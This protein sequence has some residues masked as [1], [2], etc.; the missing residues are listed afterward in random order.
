MFGWLQKIF[1][2]ET[3]EPEELTEEKNARVTTADRLHFYLQARSLL[4]IQIT[5][6]MAVAAV[7]MVAVAEIEVFEISLCT[8]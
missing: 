1:G 8:V 5:Q 2:S 7:G 4:K 3:N 6:V